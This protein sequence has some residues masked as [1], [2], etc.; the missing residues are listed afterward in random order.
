MILGFASEAGVI[1]F[2]GLWRIRFRAT[3]ESNKNKLV[4]F[5]I[6]ICVFC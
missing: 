4:N 6:T 1:V 3:Y 5:V 2:P